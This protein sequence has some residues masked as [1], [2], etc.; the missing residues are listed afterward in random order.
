MNSPIDG[1]E[2]YAPRW[3]REPN[4]ETRHENPSTAEGEFPQHSEQSVPKDG[5]IPDQARAHRPLDRASLREALD[6]LARRPRAESELPEGDEEPP[7]HM[8]RSLDPQFVREPPPAPRALGRLAALAGLK[9]RNILS[10]GDAEGAHVP[11]QKCRCRF[12]ALFRDGTVQ[13]QN[14]PR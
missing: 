13:F 10:Q 11:A 9:I 6:S 8:P 5:L 12:Q 14:S 4:R 1:P 7:L 2:K 3:V